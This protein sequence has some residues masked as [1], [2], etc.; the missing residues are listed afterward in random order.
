MTRRGGVRG[1]GRP[2]TF[3]ASATDGARAIGPARAGLGRRPR[4]CNPAQRGA[5]KSAAAFGGAPGARAAENALHHRPSA[6]RARWA[7]PRPR[8]PPAAAAPPLK[9]MR[10][11][12]SHLAGGPRPGRGSRAPMAARAPAR[13]SPRPPHSPPPP[14]QHPHRGAG[15]GGE[16][17]QGEDGGL[18]HGGEG[19]EGFVEALCSTG[20]RC[21]ISAK[22]G[23]KLDATVAR[24]PTR[25]PT[26]GGRRLGARRP[27]PPPFAAA[28]AR[29]GRRPTSPGAAAAPAAEGARLPVA[30]A[31]GAGRG[32]GSPGLRRAL[33]LARAADGRRPPSQHAA[34]ALST[35]PAPRSSRAHE[36]GAFGRETRGA[37]A[38]RWAIIEIVESKLHCCNDYDFF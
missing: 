25:T 36:R 11:W 33:S 12:P 4:A 32:G 37:G 13:A 9:Y 23:A 19:G 31:P 18:G 24:G 6:W 15:D 7:G 5:R 1:L 14:S 28:R 29:R 27:P 22:R 16:R 8:T 38:T 35:S 26:A 20:A 30:N 17:A 21:L 10:G 3:S 2:E 34:E